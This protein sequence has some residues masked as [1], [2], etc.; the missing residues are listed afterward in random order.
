MKTLLAVIKPLIQINAAVVTCVF[1]IGAIRGRQAEITLSKEQLIYSPDT[2]YREIKE[3]NREKSGQISENSPK[4]PD[5]TAKKPNKAQN[6]EESP[7]QK[8]RGSAVKGEQ[9]QP[10]IEASQPKSPT[11]KNGQGPATTTRQLALQ[12]ESLR[13]AEGERQKYAGESRLFNS[14]LPSPP[15]TRPPQAPPPSP[16]PSPNQ[17]PASQTTPQTSQAEVDRHQEQSA[18]Y[19]NDIAAGLLV[20]H[21]QGQLKYG[22]KMYRKVQSAIRVLRRGG[23]LVTAAHRAQV[24]LPT[25]QQLIKWGEIR[26]GS[27]VASNNPSPRS[28]YKGSENG[29]DESI[30]QANDIAAGLLVADTKGQINYG[31]RT[32]RKVQTAI[33]LLRRGGTLEIAARQA[34]LSTATLQQLIEWGANRPGSFNEAKDQI[35]LAEPTGTP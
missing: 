2:H 35:T 34:N 31:T 3:I 19:A 22:T 28:D 4:N 29:R 5:N 24:P 25:L 13:R 9:Q 20:A 30:R 18:R 33:R 11:A 15:A 6:L 23:T 8:A 17:Q 10:A 26:P 14:Q 21:Q 1:L 32:Y 16:P 7:P 27:S 12:G